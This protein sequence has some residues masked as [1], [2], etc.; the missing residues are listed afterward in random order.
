LV[1]TYQDNILN[2]YDNW[3][4]N[5]KIKMINPVLQGTGRIAEQP[6]YIIAQTGVENEISIDA[7]NQDYLLAGTEVNR[8]IQV[9]MFNVVLTEANGMSLFTRIKY[10]SDRLGILNSHEALYVLDFKIMARKNG[11]NSEPVEVPNSSSR[12]IARCTNIMHDYAGGTGSTYQMVLYEENY[13]SYETPDNKINSVITVQGQTLGEFAGNLQQ[14]LQENEDDETQQSI[15]KGFPTQ[16]IIEYPSQWNGYVFAQSQ[17]ARSGETFNTSTDADGNTIFEFP[18]GTTVTTMMASA[19]TNTYEFRNVPT[20]GGGF[21]FSSAEKTDADPS[22]IAD[23]PYWYYFDNEVKFLK[24]DPAANAYQ[25][26]TKFKMIRYAT[27]ELLCDRNSHGELLNDLGLQKKR[28]RNYV[29]NNLLEKRYDWTF[30]GLNT[31]VIDVEIQL[32]NV[33]KAMS[34]IKGGTFDDRAAYFTGEP[35]DEFNNL[36]KQISNISTDIEKIQNS[37]SSELGNPTLRNPALE[38][39]RNLQLQRDELQDKLDI[40]PPIGGSPVSIGQDRYITQSDLVRGGSSGKDPVSRNLRFVSEIFNSL[41]T[42]GADEGTVADSVAAARLGAIE[43]TQNQAV[44]LMNLNITIKGDPYWLGSHGNF[45]EGGPALFLN[46]NLPT[47]TKDSDTTVSADPDWNI[48]GLY[49]VFSINSKCQGGQWIMQL[50]TFRDVNSDISLI[51]NDLESG[52]IR[53]DIETIAENVL[54]VEQV[55]ADRARGVL[56]GF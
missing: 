55:I 53:D 36:N 17:A 24:Y 32:N 52:E 7:V 11:I 49:R 39:I 48:S 1:S 44:D 18:A 35:I 47:Y 15:N 8:S 50:R 4:Y 51:Y 10:A 9:S 14:K 16:Y 40:L 43:V 42:N 31:E 21:C 13:A 12:W 56:K 5:W 41:S 46:I 6:G 30:T 38:K 33:Y 54:D 28:V 23:F 34:V 19:L 27:P 22:A 29:R 26:E 3:T 45:V 37:I 20:L 2:K 25:R